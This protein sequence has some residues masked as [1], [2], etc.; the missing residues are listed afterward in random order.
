MDK[1]TVCKYSICMDLHD[2]AHKRLE[3]SRWLA[4]YQDDTAWR[5]IEAEHYAYLRDRANELLQLGEVSPDTRN[6]IAEAA[7]EKYQAYLRLNTAAETQWAWHYEYLVHEAETL[8]GKIGGEGHLFA[9]PDRQLMGCISVTPGV[10]PRLIRY[11]D[12]DPVVVGIV[13]GLLIKR[14]DAEP[15]RMTLIRNPNAKRWAAG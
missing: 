7:F 12:Y 8:I 11:V 3:L 2:L 1:N 15:W 9:H 14:P 4:A 13:D 10:V 6:R 5:N